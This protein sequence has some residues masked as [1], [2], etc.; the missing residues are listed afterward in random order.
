MVFVFDAK[1][2]VFCMWVASTFCWLSGQLPGFGVNGRAEAR[3]WFGWPTCLH[4]P[5]SWQRPISY[6]H[7]THALSVPMPW[8]LA[9]DIGSL[10]LRNA[11]SSSHPISF[12]SSEFATC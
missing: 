7:L 12:L 4:Q 3:G 9:D 6:L 5:P 2:A 11:R 1:S 8:D 10:I